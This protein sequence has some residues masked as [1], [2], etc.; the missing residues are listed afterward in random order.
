MNLRDGRMSVL[1]RTAREQ[2]WR[3]DEAGTKLTWYPPDGTTR[4]IT[5]NKTFSESGHD[6]P[7]FLGELRRAGLVVRPNGLAAPD[8]QPAKP[9]IDRFTLELAG[10]IEQEMERRTRNL[11]DQVDALQN[12]NEHLRSELADSKA[13]V[14]RELEAA[15]ADAQAMLRRI[16]P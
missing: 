11:Q 9:T 15:I 6:F 5:S 10:L 4:P 7:N 8:P 12:E 1:A 3:I 14:S 16:K 2:G 13:K